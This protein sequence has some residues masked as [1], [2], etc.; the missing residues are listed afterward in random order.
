MEQVKKKPL[1]CTILE[2]EG[3]LSPEM[4]RRALSAWEARCAG[5]RRVPFGQVVLSLGM[6]SPGDMVGYLAMQ[7]KLAG[8]PG[9]APLGVL[10]VEHGVLKPSQLVGALERRATSGK[11][12][13]ELLLEEGL[14]RRI[15]V[16]MLLQTQKRATAR[17]L[18]A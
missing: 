3:V 8:A 17:S 1:L 7:R 18:A 10:L 6:V 14:V 9:T 11:R 5:G 13:G 2:T 4:A 12:L 16:D 15:Q